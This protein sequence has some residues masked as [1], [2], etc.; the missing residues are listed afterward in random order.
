MLTHSYSFDISKLLGFL[1]EGVSL[2]AH[3]SAFNRLEQPSLFM[4]PLPSNSALS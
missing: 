4:S 3:L 1:C 2:M